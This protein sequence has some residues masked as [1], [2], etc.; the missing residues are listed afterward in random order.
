MNTT[1]IR[2][3]DG[4][5]VKAVVVK[6]TAKRVQVRVPVI[7]YGVVSWDSMTVPTDRADVAGEPCNTEKFNRATAAAGARIEAVRFLN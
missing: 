3:V 6:R 2:L 1:T 7:M 5:V 4:A